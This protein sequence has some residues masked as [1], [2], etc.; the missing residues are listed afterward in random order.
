MTRK[1]SFPAPWADSV[2][3]NG[4]VH[5]VGW[6]AT[7]MAEY[8]LA[9]GWF[10]RSPMGGLDQRYR[11]ASDTKKGPPKP[12]LGHETCNCEFSR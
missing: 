10:K 3:E 12:V 11:M 5:T 2:W 1:L 9:G 7:A 4:K 8:I 6:T